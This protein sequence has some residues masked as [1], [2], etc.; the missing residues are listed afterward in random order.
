MTLPGVKADVFQVNETPERESHFAEKLV[1][2]GGNFSIVY[3][4]TILDRLYP[5]LQNGL[6]AQLR[7]D[8][9]RNGAI[10]GHGVYVT[11]AIDI[12]LSY[13]RSSSRNVTMAR[14]G[15]EQGTY[16]VK[17]LLICKVVNKK[18]WETSNPDILVITDSANLVIRLVIMADPDEGLGNLDFRTVH[19]YIRVSKS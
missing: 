3:H 12:A 17:V 9:I 6:Q 11:P 5:I 8:M 19:Q 15:W 7:P 1:P 14:L 18:G 10:Y 2:T 4:G 13:S 16:P